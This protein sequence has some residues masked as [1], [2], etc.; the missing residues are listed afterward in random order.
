M[1][2]NNSFEKVNRF[3]KPHWKKKLLDNLGKIIMN[4]NIYSKLDSDLGK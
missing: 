3:V 1:S 2:E 4:L